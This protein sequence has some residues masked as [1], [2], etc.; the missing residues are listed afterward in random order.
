MTFNYQLDKDVVARTAANLSFNLNN[1]HSDIHIKNH[2]RIINGK[3]LVGVLQG[4]LKFGDTI[5]IYI[6]DLSEVNKIKEYFSEIGK[7]VD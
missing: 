5:T 1:F 6:N 7:E 2:N 3:S 4:N